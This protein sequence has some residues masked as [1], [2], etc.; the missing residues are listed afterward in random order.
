MPPK[1]IGNR[2]AGARI[3]WSCRP[4]VNIGQ[5]GLN[6]ILHGPEQSRKSASHNLEHSP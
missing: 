4:V 3:R 6:L 2:N 1:A 5:I